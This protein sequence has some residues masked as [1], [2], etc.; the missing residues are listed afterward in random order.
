[1][2]S[3]WCLV[4]LMTALVLAGCGGSSS[5]NSSSTT[6]A[7]ITS[8]PVSDTTTT[9]STS[10]S[11]TTSRSTSSSTPTASSTTVS[12][13]EATAP[14]PIPSGTPPAPAGLAR[15]TGYAMYENCTEHCSGAV[16]SALRRPLVF[17]SM[18]GQSCPIRAARGPITPNISTHVR[19]SGFL[20]SKWDGAPVTWSPAAGFTGPLLIR[21]R[22]LGGPGAVGF[23]EGHTPY[24]ELQIYAAAGH[25]KTWPAFVRVR[26][27]GCYAI[28]IDTAHTSAVFV[29]EATG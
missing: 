24:D 18:S 1:M 29:F 6:A 22:Q 4:A 8:S 25:A 14:P 17:P 16:P 26:A 15:T 11:R 20:G 28:D 21:G 13:E 10:S 2:R 7:S 19:V 12:S 9:M 3:V 27:P 5:S 23:G